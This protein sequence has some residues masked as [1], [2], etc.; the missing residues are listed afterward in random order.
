MP[1]L[2]PIAD[3]GRYISA[4]T[5]WNTSLTADDVHRR[6]PADGRYFT[7]EEPVNC[8]Y[9]GL[10]N[11]A[12]ASL[13]SPLA[14]HIPTQ[15]REQSPEAGVTEMDTTTPGSQATIDS[16]KLGAF[17]YSIEAIESL[18]QVTTF[19]LQQRI[20]WQNRQHVLDWL[21]RFKELD[22]RLIQYVP[23][24]S[25]TGMQLWLTCIAGRCSF[26]PAGKTPTSL[27]TLRILI[28]TQT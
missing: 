8:P 15:Y 1:S 21:T 28:W 5:G 19:F 13:G 12:H 9:F 17:A 27:S 3:S 16:S 2:V 14:T 25:T 23:M 4:H 11:K 24:E 22:L 20:N 26:R 7:R 18:H 6:L 10:W